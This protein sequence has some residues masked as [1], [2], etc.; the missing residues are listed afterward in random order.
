MPTIWEP[1]TKSSLISA[2]INPLQPPLHHQ[3]LQPK[4]QQ[5][6]VVLVQTTTHANKRN[7]DN[8]DVDDDVNDNVNAETHHHGLMPSILRRRRFQSGEFK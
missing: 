1:L 5:E 3:E 7:S 8:I 2:A 4:Q 6:E